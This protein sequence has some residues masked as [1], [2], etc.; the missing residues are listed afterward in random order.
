MAD[1]GLPVFCPIDGSM[2]QIID[3]T[4]VCEYCSH[5]WEIHLPEGNEYYTLELIGY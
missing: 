4:Y 1:Y 2:F 3:G 5:N